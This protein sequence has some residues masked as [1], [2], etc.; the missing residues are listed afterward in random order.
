[1]TGSFILGLFCMGAGVY[2]LMTGKLMMR[3]WYK[4]E[5]R[6][7]TYWFGVSFY[8]LAGVYGLSVDFFK[9]L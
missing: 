2:A 5:E 6:P 4:K 1:M 8:L 9:S 3:G 7:F